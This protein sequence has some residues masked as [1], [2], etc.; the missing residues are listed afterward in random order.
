MSRS[1]ISFGKID[2][3]L[4]ATLGPTHAAPDPET[5]FRVLVL[6]DFSGRAN[7]GVCE[8]NT[9]AAR[10]PVFVDRDNFEQVLA[11][12]GVE[13]R[14]ALAGSHA[15]NLPLR[16]AELDDFHPDRLVQQVELF[17]ALRDLRRRLNNPKTFPS[18][19]EEVRSWGKLPA[20]PAA[21]D[22]SPAPAT[23]DTGALMEHLLGQAPT[24]TVPSES[25]DWNAFL[26]QI[27]GPHVT[28]REDP[29]KDDL[30]ALV[31]EA[32]SGQMQ[33]ILHQPAFQALE[34][35]WRGLFFLVRRL[36]TDAN[37]K[38]YLLDISRAELAADLG[39]A[40]DLS[41]TAFCKL[42]VEQT[43]GTP[44]AQPWALVVGNYAFDQKQTDVELLG[45]LAKVVQAAGAPLLAAASPAL[46]GCTSLA[47]TPDPREWQEP[48]DLEAWQALRRL[49]EAAWLGLAL[50]RFLLRVPYGCDSSPAEQFDFEEM[51]S[52]LDN[53]AYLW[54]NPAFACAYLLAEAFSRYGWKL[55]PGIVDA[56]DGLP[57]HVS[58]VEDEDRVQPCAEVVLNDR[59]TAAI[60]EK[61]LIVLR[62]VQN[63]DVVQVAGFQS[64]AEPAR[65]LAGR[66][67]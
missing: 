32:T 20:E 60:L 53:E 23:T 63:R 2:V 50:P 18:A 30:V 40:D 47:A 38:L 52:P 24:P 33:A 36:D 21:A 67:H 43:R 28:P 5:P 15:P 13:L 7:R 3:N 45:R 17:E 59:A 22:P 27:V 61:G 39:A 56:I 29:Q 10:R 42:L 46:L 8:P 62:S 11:K 31:D 6:G 64:V 58:Q 44:G 4:G 16:F 34:A 14:L 48:A 66:W 26:G 49:P 51:P 35:A 37:L 57:L 41:A 19:A 25:V 1:P 65:P 55:R 12:L 9:L 54:G